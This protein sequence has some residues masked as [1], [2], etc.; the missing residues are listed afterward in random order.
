MILNGEYI[1]AVSLMTLLLNLF[2]SSTKQ[3]EIYEYQEMKANEADAKA[4]YNELVKL[5]A[6]PSRPVR[7]EFAYHTWTYKRGD[8][9]H[10][11]KVEWYDP[12]NDALGHADE[13]SLMPCHWL[14]E[15]MAF[16]GQLH[17]WKEFR[18]AQETSKGDPNLRNSLLVRPAEMPAPESADP[19]LAKHLTTIQDWRAYRAYFKGKVARL[20]SRRMTAR[21][22]VSHLWW[23]FFRTADLPRKDKIEAELKKN[24]VQLNVHHE[25]WLAEKAHLGRVDTEILKILNETVHELSVHDSALLIQY[26]EHS[27]STA[28][29]LA[30]QLGTLSSSPWPLRS[31]PA[32]LSAVDQL[33]QWEREISRLSD[34]YKEWNENIESLR[35]NHDLKDGNTTY[36]LSP[37]PSIIRDRSLWERHV[38]SRQQQLLNAQTWERCWK[39]VEN[40]CMKEGDA[41]LWSYLPTDYLEITRKE[42]GLAYFSMKEATEAL[43][44]AEQEAAEALTLLDQSKELPKCSRE[45]PPTWVDTKIARKRKA[46]DEAPMGR[47]AKRIC[48]SW[49]AFAAGKSKKPQRHPVKTST[50]PSVNSTWKRYRST[51]RTSKASPSTAVNMEGD[52][53]SW[54]G[55]NVDNFVVPQHQ[56]LSSVTPET[57]NSTAKRDRSGSP[58]PEVPPSL[59]PNIEDD[60]LSWEGSTADNSIV[61]QHRPLPSAASRSADNAP[62]TTQQARSASSPTTTSAEDE[63]PQVQAKKTLRGKKARQTSQAGK[64][65]VSRSNKDRVKA[66]ATKTGR[67]TKPNDYRA[68]AKANGGVRRSERI[69]EMKKN[70]RCREGC[71]EMHEH[72]Y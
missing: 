62:S 41:Q 60:E 14:I 39:I 59:A 24:V 29:Y 34:L 64:G 50:S 18:K 15:R 13:A 42:Q 38:Q 52:K 58:C 51:S 69:K 72:L 43:T 17:R 44:I 21:D 67:V 10:K 26:Q 47:Q 30:D 65:A 11:G 37:K 35:M 46:D 9:K 45:M 2:P 36:L 23:T 61:P 53:I 70:L 57:T 54:E 27:A 71:T 19:V 4:A 40:F 56:P 32:S 66:S 25:L 3:M 7:E 55:S 8:S 1:F 49:N 20:D 16:E 33:Y 6:R 48:L 28:Q 5:G 63:G 22:Q 31:P 12:E 68:E